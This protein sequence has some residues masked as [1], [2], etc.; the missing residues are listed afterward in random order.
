MQEDQVGRMTR[1]QSSEDQPIVMCAPLLE[2]A[3]ATPILSSSSSTSKRVAN[4]CMF[5]DAAHFRVQTSSPAPA[6]LSLSLSLSSVSTPPKRSP[7]PTLPTLRHN[8][9]L[10]NMTHLPSIT[11]SQPA[12]ADPQCGSPSESLSVV[13]TTCH[14]V[15]L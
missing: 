3:G 1:L 6:C 9:V 14:P 4:I 7:S 10:S 5:N 11:T 15:R 12:Q 8:L 13:S 2:K